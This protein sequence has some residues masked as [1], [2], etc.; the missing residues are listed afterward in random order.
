MAELSCL[1]AVK[2]WTRTPSALCLEAA[3]QEEATVHLIRVWDNPDRL[4][5]IEVLEEDEHRV[6]VHYTGYIMQG[7][8]PDMMNGSGIVILFS[9]LPNNS[10]MNQTF[11]SCLSW[12]AASRSRFSKQENRLSC[13]DPATIRHERRGSPWGIPGMD[14][15]PTSTS[16]NYWETNG[17]YESQTSM[18]IFHTSSWRLFAST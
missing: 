11:L 18:E 5:K 1:T 3:A 4:Y 10:L 16:V 9:S 8:V 14:Y 13:K 15:S 17:T 7:T 12:L 2:E 6:K